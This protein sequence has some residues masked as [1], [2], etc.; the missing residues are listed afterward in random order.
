M[1]KWTYWHK[2]GQIEQEGNYKD[3]RVDGKWTYWHKNGQKSEERNYKDDKLVSQTKY[4]Y[5]ENG[6]IKEKV[7]IFLIHCLFRITLTK[8]ITKMIS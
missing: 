3:G 6:Q 5:F 8:E 7:K 1:A 2:N 4:K